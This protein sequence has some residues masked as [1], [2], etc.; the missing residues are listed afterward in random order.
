VVFFQLLPSGRTGSLE[1]AAH[2]NRFAASSWEWPDL[3]DPWLYNPANVPVA[4]PYIIVC[5]FEQVCYGL[6]G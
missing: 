4:N 3:A 2:S 5:D 1:Y 6:T